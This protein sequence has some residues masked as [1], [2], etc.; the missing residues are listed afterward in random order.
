[1]WCRIMQYVPQRTIGGAMYFPFSDWL[2]DP[3]PFFQVSL[4][5]RP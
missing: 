3:H 2:C 4:S 1:M 5:S